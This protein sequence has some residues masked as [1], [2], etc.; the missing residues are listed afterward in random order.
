VFE[1]NSYIEI[2]GSSEKSFGLVFAIFFMIISLY[3]IL[4]GENLRL[5]ALFISI[6]LCFLSYF[7]PKVLIIP[8]KLWIKFGMLLGNIIAPLIMGI[9]FIF[10][11]TPIGLI[12][13]L[14]G[15]DILNQKIDKSKKSYWK[16]K[17][18]SISSMKNQF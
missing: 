7:L 9:I 5:W 11:V 2:K 12:M 3:P 8:N 13:R 1:N 6:I 18:K 16:K 4:Q 17:E 14:I 10:V 15:K